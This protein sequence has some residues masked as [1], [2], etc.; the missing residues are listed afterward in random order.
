MKKF[1][2]GLGIFVAVVVVIG[3]MIFG[4]VTGT[5]NMLVNQRMMC[6]TAWAQ[7]E[8]QYQRR[9]D[10]IPNLV[11]A[12]KGYL[13][14]EQTV[15]KAIADARTHYAGAVGED[16]IKAQGA[17]DSALARL[18]VIIENYPNLK[19]NQTISDLMFELSGTENRVNVSRQRYNETTQL[20]DTS[21]QSFPTNII[22]GNFNFKEKQLYQSQTGADQAPKIN[23]ELK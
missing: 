22:A 5:Y 16:K 20:Y 18:L 12:T 19:A 10:L 6:N 21:I 9:F 4:W 11:E 3:F 14:H 2:I 13:Q 8:T 17:L 1:L 7:V 23:M 15:F